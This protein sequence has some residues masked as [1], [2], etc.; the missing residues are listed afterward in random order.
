[1]TNPPHPVR[2]GGSQDH[3]PRAARTTAFDTSAR[4]HND[5]SKRHRPAGEVVAM[6][7]D[8]V[9]DAPALSRAN[10][11]VAIGHGGTEIAKAAADI[12]L[13]EDDFSTIEAPAKAAACSRTSPNSFP[14]LF[15]PIWVTIWSSWSPLCSEPRCHPADSDPVDHHDQR[16]GAG[17]DADVRA[18][19]ARNHVP[20]SAPTRSAIPDQH[21]DGPDPIG[22]DTARS[23]ILVVV[24]MGAIP[25]RQPREA[26]TA[27]LNLFIA[28]VSLVVAIGK[29]VRNRQRADANAG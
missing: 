24:P 9:N 13:T 18:E 16:R 7:G 19:E 14:G 15:L 23:W 17:I 6:T 29:R 28:A 21:T 26:R 3:A 4:A 25:W 12:V 20:A 2:P 5:S 11:G 1:M 8:G 22:I 10:I 27:P